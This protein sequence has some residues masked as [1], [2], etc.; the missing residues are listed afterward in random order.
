MEDCTKTSK[1][2]R[3]ALLGYALWIVRSDRI[4]SRSPLPIELEYSQTKLTTVPA[5][6]PVVSLHLRDFGQRSP[7]DSKHTDRYTSMYNVPRSPGV[8]LEG[9]EMG[10]PYLCQGISC[11]LQVLP[12]DVGTVLC[13]DILID[14][15]QEFRP[16]LFF[17]FQTSLMVI[18]LEEG[19]SLADQLRSDRPVPVRS[20]ADT[21]SRPLVL[22]S[23]GSPVAIEVGHGIW[24]IRNNYSRAFSNLI[25]KMRR[26]SR[27]ENWANL[28]DTS[29]RNDDCRRNRTRRKIE[30]HWVSFG[31]PSLTIW[32][33]PKEKKCSEAKRILKDLTSVFLDANFALRTIFRIR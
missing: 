3:Y 9:G 22:D 18:P 2:Q 21:S 8:N 1:E 14:F 24:N 10:R 29:N 25:R 6:P 13:V 27:S 7:L 20:S 11:F 12:I 4:D 16:R 32:L 23:E 26:R 31:W 19:S 30:M 33:H 28:Q 17:E 5:E 15:L